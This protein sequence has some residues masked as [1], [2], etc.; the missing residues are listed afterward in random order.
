LGITQNAVDGLGRETTELVFA[1]NYCPSST[2]M[3]A[4]RFCLFVQWRVARWDQGFWDA[5]KLNGVHPLAVDVHAKSPPRNWLS[6]KP[7]HMSSSWI[8]AVK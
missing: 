6:T 3:K 8:R 1:F 5:P 2:S 7:T 4:K